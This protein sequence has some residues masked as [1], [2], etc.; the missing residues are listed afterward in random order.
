[1]PA[2]GTYKAN[3]I[4]GVGHERWSVADLAE[5]HRIG[6]IQRRGLPSSM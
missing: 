1:M 4:L 3:L 2:F 6:A 5:I